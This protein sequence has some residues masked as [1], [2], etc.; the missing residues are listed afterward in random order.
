[1]RSQSITKLSI[2]LI[3]S[4][5]ILIT[6]Q[7]STI[8]PDDKDVIDSTLNGSWHL[9]ASSENGAEFD[10]SIADFNVLFFFNEGTIE[11]DWGGMQTFTGVYTIDTEKNPKELD[12]ELSDGTPWHHN[13]VLCIYKFESLD[14]LAVKIIDGIETRANNFDLDPNYD[15]YKLSYFES[16]TK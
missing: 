2:F 7:K 9:T 1:M 15:I 16:S 4:S 13:P 6:C 14:V 12:I 3:A 10:E 11:I 5:L 8:E